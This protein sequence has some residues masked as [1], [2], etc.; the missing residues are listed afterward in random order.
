MTRLASILYTL[1]LLALAPVVFAQSPA[2]IPSYPAN[3]PAQYGANQNQVQTSSTNA[4]VSVTIAAAA[5][6][7]AYVYRVD[8]RCSAGT[9]TVTITDNAVTVWSTSTGA[10]STTNLT[11]QWNPPLT[12]TGANQAMVVTLGT[13]GGGNTGV[14]VV[15]GDRW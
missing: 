3:H 12:S 10:V 4:A 13:C 8:A 6:Q 1:I 14:L 2:P 5:N 15:Q 7:R 9:A 11:N